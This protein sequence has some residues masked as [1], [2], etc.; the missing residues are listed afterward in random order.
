MPHITYHPPPT[1]HHQIP[2]IWNVSYQLRF[3]ICCR[4]YANGNSYTARSKSFL[5]RIYEG[6]STFLVSPMHLCSHSHQ[7]FHGANLLA[8]W[9]FVL[10]FAL[11]FAF[12]FTFAFALASRQMEPPQCIYLLVFPL[13]VAFGFANRIPRT[14]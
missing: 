5:L 4:Q 12:I 8:T 11:T 13:C 10:T 1:T 7:S 14:T 2:H 3:Q 6:T 9:T